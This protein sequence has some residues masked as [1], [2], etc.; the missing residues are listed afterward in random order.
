[1]LKRLPY[2]LAVASEQ[3]FGRAAHKLNISQPPLSQQIRKFE[4]ELG[5]T[6]FRRTTR[7]V[8]LTEAGEFFFQRIQPLLKELDGVVEAT[9]ALHRDGKEEIRFGA[10]ATAA[11][12]IFPRLLKLLKEKFPQASFHLAQA[13]AAAIKQAIVD[14]RIDLGIV[15]DTGDP[16]FRS[17]IVAYEPLFVGFPLEHPLGQCPDV[18]MREL[19]AEKFI[20][21]DRNGA[22]AM[23]TQT[24]RLFARHGIDPDVA[25]R[26]SQFFVMLS[27]VGQGWG[28]ALVPETVARLG[29][30]GVAFRQL[31]DPDAYSEVAL[32]WHPHTTSRLTQRFADEVAQAPCPLDQPVGEPA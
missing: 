18:S 9:R 8:E 20:M 3:H 2:F 4:E 23:A 6:L 7:N 24:Q 1:M 17:K 19:R 29:H 5:V 26:S 27:L 12:S 14:K 22:S 30:P 21:W 32:I 13:S 16:A 25:Q 28:I 11:Y 31:R 10:V 15:R